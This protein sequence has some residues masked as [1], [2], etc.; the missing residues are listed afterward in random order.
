P[1]TVT[2]NRTRCSPPA[3]RGSDTDLLAHSA[4][5][6]T[7][8]APGTGIPNPTLT[9]D[10]ATGRVGARIVLAPGAAVPPTIHYTASSPG[11]TATVIDSQL[12]DEVLVA[13][14][15]YSQAAGTLTVN[16]ASSD[17]VG[18]PPLTAAGT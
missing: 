5:N 2:D 7:V 4:G 15:T 10:P 18:A 3:P 9:N 12:I 16:P 11:S 14:A 6:G 1:T 17:Q 8:I 13:G